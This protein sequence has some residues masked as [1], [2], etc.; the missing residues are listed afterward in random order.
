LATSL[1]LSTEAEA[2]GDGEG[3]GEG[4][5]AEGSSAGDVVVDVVGGVVVDGVVVDGVVVVGV[6]AVDV[7]V[8]AVVVATVEPGETEGGSAAS[9]VATP[10]DTIAPVNPTAVATLFHIPPLLLCCAKL[11]DFCISRDCD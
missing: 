8:D 2:G 3:E 11:L 1:G 5:G 10:A 7:V 4:E 6:V 9:E